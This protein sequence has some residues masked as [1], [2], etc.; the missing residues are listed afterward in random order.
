LE[1]KVEDL[2]GAGEEEGNPHDTL[3]T[4]L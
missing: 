3:S 4:N 2:R 1:Q